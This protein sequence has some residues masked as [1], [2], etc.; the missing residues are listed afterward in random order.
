MGNFTLEISLVLV[1]LSFFNVVLAGILVVR[2]IMEAFV[3]FSQNSRVT[4]DIIWSFFYNSVAPSL[5]WYDLWKYHS[6]PH[7]HEKGFD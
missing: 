6:K 3:V 7:R 2:Y 4:T 1:F 5:H